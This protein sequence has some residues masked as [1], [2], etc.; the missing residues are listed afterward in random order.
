MKS[1]YIKQQEQS[2]TLQEVIFPLKY[3]M[4]E[5]LRDIKLY[6]CYRT[7]ELN[8]FHRLME[9]KSLSFFIK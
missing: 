6:K 1:N 8:K 3:K 2:D 4:M 7:K 5:L 9:K